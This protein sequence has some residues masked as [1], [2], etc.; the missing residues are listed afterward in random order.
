[1]YRVNGNPSS[2]SA[3]SNTATQIGVLIHRRRL[4]RCDQSPIR[5]D[6]PVTS[7]NAQAPTPQSNS[8]NCSQ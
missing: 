2:N 4:R 8:H 6:T 5:R 3:I 1:V 7:N